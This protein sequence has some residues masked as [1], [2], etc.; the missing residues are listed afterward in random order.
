MTS[1]AAG[2]NFKFTSEFLKN[3]N[4]RPYS[5]VVRTTQTVTASRKWRELPVKAFVSAPAARACPLPVI[6]STLYET[7]LDETPHW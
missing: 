5:S 2:R 6:Q 7:N 3:N 4:F 1:S